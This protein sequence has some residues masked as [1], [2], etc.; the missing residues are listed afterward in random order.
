MAKTIIFFLVLHRYL[1]VN[2]NFL[3]A[4]PDAFNF[5]PEK[6]FSTLALK[7]YFLNSP[8]ISFGEGR[9]F[10]LALV[11]LCQRVHGQHEEN[12]LI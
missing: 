5:S 8:Q 10:H 12:H 11:G 9:D 2:S 6:I 7:K 1:L 4:L 3:S